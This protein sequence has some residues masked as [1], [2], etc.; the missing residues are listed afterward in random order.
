MTDNP[1]IRITGDG[2][3]REAADLGRAVAQGVATASAGTT[4]ARHIETLRIKLPANSGA[5]ALE[6]AIRSA[7]EKER[8]R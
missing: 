8:D 4:G 2:S 1:T 3:R 7:L 5:A 6:Q